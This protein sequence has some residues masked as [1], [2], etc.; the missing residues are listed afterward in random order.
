MCATDTQT[1]MHSGHGYGDDGDGGG[2]AVRGQGVS[3]LTNIPGA[4]AH[5]WSLAA[6]LALQQPVPIESAA[7]PS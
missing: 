4:K 1:R 3:V 7:G 2:K 5:V 6:S